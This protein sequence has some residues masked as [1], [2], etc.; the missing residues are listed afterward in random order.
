MSKY[1]YVQNQ[2][3]STL[4]FTF[5]LFCSFTLLKGVFVEEKGLLAENFHYRTLLF[6]LLCVKRINDLL[7]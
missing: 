5:Y 7:L 6:Y 3:L 1:V 4:L 2:F